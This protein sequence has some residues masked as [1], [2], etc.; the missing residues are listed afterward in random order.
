MQLKNYQN[1]VLAS[2]L[3]VVEQA[4]TVKINKRA[5]KKIA[6]Q[7]GRQKIPIITWDRTKHLCTEDE[8]L[9]L[10]YI[11]VLDSL[12]FCFWAQKGKRWTIRYEDKEYNGYW[13]LALA[14]KI[15]FEKEPNKAN[16][17]YFSKISFNEFKTILQGGERLLFLKKRW[18]ILRQVSKVIQN[19]YQG[20]IK[21][22]VLSA[23]HKCANLVLK[24]AKEL[25]SFNDETQYNG[26]KI[27]FWK[28]A[29]ILAGDI[30]GALQ[31]K[32]LG[33]FNDLEYLTAFADYKIPQLLYYW[34]V[35]EY[36]PSL[37]RKIKNRI[38]IPTGSCEEIEIRSCT[39]W[40]VEELK[41]ALTKFGKKLNSFQIDWLLWNKSK[42]IEM[43]N[44][45][46]LTKTIFY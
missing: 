20:N 23:G 22:F 29:Q 44:N 4:K 26:R 35:L 9:L 17:E 10:T 7:W 30:W 21:N 15:F 32:G 14:L 16:F 24:I 31:G 1:P 8:N 38:L 25:P 6:E 28:R 5:L 12:N 11:F 42:S 33:N 37:E 46:H 39:I 27:Y 45:Y 3:W 40:A 36:A 13:A 19:N 18:Q 2:T 34:K 41:Q 43:P